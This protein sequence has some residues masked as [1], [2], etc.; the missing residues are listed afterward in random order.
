MMAEYITRNITWESDPYVIL[1][2]DHPAL[3]NVS[4]EY[5]YDS[6]W[7]CTAEFVETHIGSKVF[8]RSDL[9]AMSTESAVAE[10]ERSTAQDMADNR[11]DHLPEAAE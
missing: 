3:F 6:G 4:W 7:E 11:R 9:V 10:I 1:I 5:D 2:D 8:T